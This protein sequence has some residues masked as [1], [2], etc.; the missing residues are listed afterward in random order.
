VRPTPGHR[1]ARVR[2]KPI[3]W[4]PRSSRVSF[5]NCRR[6]C[7]DRV[8][9]CA[10]LGGSQRLVLSRELLVEALLCFIGAPALASQ[11]C[12]RGSA[13]KASMRVR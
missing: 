9:G 8:A 1:A 6:P 7:T 10:G 5:S 11:P 2:S 3:P 4:D 12:A 13:V